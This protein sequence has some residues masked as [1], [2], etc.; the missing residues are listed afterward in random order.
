ML[1]P[2]T[3]LQTRYRILRS[4]GQ[5]GMGSVYMATDQ[6]LRSTV[7]LK[8]TLFQD[9][10]LRRA[11]EHEAELLANLHHPALP[12][13]S[14]HFVEGD[15]QFL[16]MQFIQGE[17]LFQLL[18]EMKGPFPVADV[19]VWA[20]QLLDALD[21][22]HTQEPPVIHRDIKPQNL[23][24][25]ARWQIIL[26]D[27]VLDKGSLLQVS[28]MTA[29]GSIFGYTPNYAPLEQIHG[30]GTDQRSDLYALAATLYALL[31]GAP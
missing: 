15:G 20:D 22:L 13:V 9:E 16:V 3:I 26:L 11:F 27:F 19:L 10:K 6:R 1:A 8:E 5:G 14:D 25:T 28:R 2:D 31:T 30:T 24:L 21:Y 23:K 12:S 29:S 7:A 18:K 4:I 17:D